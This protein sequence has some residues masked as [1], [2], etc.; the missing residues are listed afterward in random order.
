MKIQQELQNMLFDK[1]INCEINGETLARIKEESLN[2][3]KNSVE[4][5][6]QH[7]IK[8]S[9]SFSK[10][11]SL[12]MKPCNLFTAIVLAE[13]DELPYFV[14]EFGVVELQNAK[15]KVEELRDDLGNVSYICDVYPKNLT[16]GDFIKLK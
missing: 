12:S 16:L 14:P 10:D 5:K 9:T 13:L 11:G 7:R 1:F 15:Y 6:F 8:M 4:L 2:L 3:I